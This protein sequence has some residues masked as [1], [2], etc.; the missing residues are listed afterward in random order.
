M[1][2][3]VGV[4]LALMG[5]PGFCK[6][7]SDDVGFMIGG[8]SAWEYVVKT[9]TLPPKLGRVVALAMADLITARGFQAGAREPPIAA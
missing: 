7:D 5:A 2:C 8:W 3:T 4:A 1:C 9:T 6:V